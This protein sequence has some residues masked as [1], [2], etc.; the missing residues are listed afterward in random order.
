MKLCHYH[1]VINNIVMALSAYLDTQ[2]G[3]G[4][5]IFLYRVAFVI[6]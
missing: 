3:I 1:L 4:K 5:V 2:W 6:G